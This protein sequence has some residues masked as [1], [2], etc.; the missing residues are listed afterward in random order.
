MANLV[1][2]HRPVPSADLPLSWKRSTRT[3]YGIVHVVV[4]F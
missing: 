1:S 2:Q 4:Y 3:S